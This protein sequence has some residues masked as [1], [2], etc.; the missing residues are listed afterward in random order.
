MEFIAKLNGDETTGARLLRT[1]HD[2]YSYDAVYFYY[3]M[4]VNLLKV[5]A[6]PSPIHGTGVFA[7]Y[8]I[9]PYEIV[10]LFPASKGIGQ[11][12][13]TCDQVF[14]L[15]YNF[16]KTGSELDSRYRISFCG[17]EK[18]DLYYEADADAERKDGWLGHLVNDACTLKEKSVKAVEKYFQVSRAKCNSIALHF[19]SGMIAIMSTRAIKKD[20]EILMTYG[21]I[22]YAL[23][24]EAEEIK[25]TTQRELKQYRARLRHVTALMYQDINRYN[26][27]FNEKNELASSMLHNYNLYLAASDQKHIQME[28]EKEE[29]K[30]GVKAGI[31]I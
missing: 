14:M 1:F 22:F 5:E 17:T 31:K 30:R 11:Y 15:Y 29:A 13:H 25:G 6:R 21:P 3:L 10:T 8:D 16:E 20:E 19:G 12:A 4:R 26:L 2:F 28:L 23:T 24:K 18:S 27:I 9:A 7:K